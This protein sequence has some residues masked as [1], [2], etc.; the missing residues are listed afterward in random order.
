MT[1]VARE[2][3]LDH[4]R[5]PSE[6]GAVGGHELIARCPSSFTLHLM[7]VVMGV[8]STLADAWRPVQ[9]LLQ[10]T[11]CLVAVL[12]VSGPDST[13]DAGAAR[14]LPSSAEFLNFSLP[15]FDTVTR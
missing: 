3:D 8:L 14:L 13:T 11:H 12:L 10:P 2:S 9:Q 7:V 6:L 5:A 4:T 1:A 15:W